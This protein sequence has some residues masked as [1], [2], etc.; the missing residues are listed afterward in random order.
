MK[1]GKCDCTAYAPTVLRV[2]LGLL[3]FIP[4]IGKLLNPS[5][6]IGMLDGMGFPL[7]ALFG[8]IVILV[9]VL[10]GLALILGYKTK[11]TIWPLAI[12]MVVAIF[13]TVLPAFGANPMAYINL[14]FHL[15]AIGGL[16]SLYMSGPGAKSIDVSN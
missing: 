6:I 10:G 7:A 1:L 4:G 11:Y 14:L 13:A 12:V 16:V 2:F 5:G 8:W 3:F 9:E 15:L